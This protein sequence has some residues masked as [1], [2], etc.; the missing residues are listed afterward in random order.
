M[1]ASQHAV[2]IA[3]ALASG[4][5]LATALSAAESDTPQ[6]AQGSMMN[7]GMMGGNSMMN[8]MST[9]QMTDM[10]EHCTQMMG[11]GS[12]KPNEQWRQNA[13]AAPVENK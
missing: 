12:S 3:L 11:G 13:P 8:M 6:D 7:S 1:R 9:S 5:T 10:T 4:V 2:F